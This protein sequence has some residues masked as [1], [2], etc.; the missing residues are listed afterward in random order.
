VGERTRVPS[1]SSPGFPCRLRWA[2]RGISAPPASCCS[3]RIW[4]TIVLPSPSSSAPHSTILGHDNNRLCGRAWLCSLGLGRMATSPEAITPPGAPGNIDADNVVRRARRRTRGARQQPGARH[5][6]K[7]R[8]ENHADTQ[9]ARCDRRRLAQISR[10][11][12]TLRACQPRACKQAAA[13]GLDKAADA[14][15]GRTGTSHSDAR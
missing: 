3:P 11:T 13:A 9:A 12:P 7:P 5:R 8:P 14:A 6:G 2:V 15:G 1:R 4:R 10:A